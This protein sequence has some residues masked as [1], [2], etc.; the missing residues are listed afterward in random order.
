MADWQASPVHLETFSTVLAGSMA[1]DSN[2]RAR[3][4]EQLDIAKTTVPGKS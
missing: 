1:Q 4:L 3:A 2:V